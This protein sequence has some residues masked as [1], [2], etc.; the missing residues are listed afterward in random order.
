MALT[1]YGHRP[2]KNQ[3]R[4]KMGP[5]RNVGIKG[6]PMR[7]VYGTPEGNAIYGKTAKKGKA[8]GRKSS[9]SKGSDS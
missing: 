8:K 4:G 3:P 6:A 7:A 2:I 9:K 1:K 5:Y